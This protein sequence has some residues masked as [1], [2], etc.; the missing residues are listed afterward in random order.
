MFPHLS[1]SFS[2]PLSQ[3]LPFFIQWCDV[4]GLPT[5]VLMRGG[6]G[7]PRDT[8]VA[9]FSTLRLPRSLAASLSSGEWP[10]EAPAATTA[11]S[12][13]PSLPEALSSL[14]REHRVRPLSEAETASA[15]PFTHEAR[16]S[17]AGEEPEVDL[18]AAFVPIWQLL[19]RPLFA[20]EGDRAGARALASALS[21]REGT[22]GRIARA[23]VEEAARGREEAAAEA[24][25][26][27]GLEEKNV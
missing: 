2:L 10:A 5:I 13:S 25:R 17:E 19:P 27:R 20:F 16:P 8:V 18:A 11:T 1:L 23:A 15:C 24:K 12:A 9:D 21:D 4:A 7:D 6:G 22:V 26:K 14:A 3:I